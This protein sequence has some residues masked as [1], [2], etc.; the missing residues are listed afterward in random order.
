MGRWLFNNNLVG[1]VPE[2]MKA[3]LRTMGST[4]YVCFASRVQKRTSALLLN[5]AE[6]LGTAYV[7]SELTLDHALLAACSSNPG[8]RYSTP[9]WSLDAPRRVQTSMNSAA[10]R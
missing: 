4:K 1:V 8:I 9:V 10:G 2:E 6:P 5:L 3:H 7:A